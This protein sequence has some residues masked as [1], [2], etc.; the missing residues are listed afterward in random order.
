MKKKD[1]V[2]LLAEDEES[3]QYVFASQ[4]KALGYRSP[5]FVS[6]GID[7]V[8]LALQKRIDIIFMDIRMPGLDGI[9]ATLRIREQEKDSTI[10]IIGLSAFA[11]KAACL[12]AGMNDY[13]QKPVM[14]YQV[15][16]MINKHLNITDKP[17]PTKLLSEPAKIEVAQD[18]YSLEDEKLK[19]IREKMDNLRKHTDIF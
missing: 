12:S 10:P 14:L 18:K 17:Q 1:A 2:I 13:M 8:K 9:S 4:I 19:N 11:Q 15:E 16:E 5:E 6:N 7:A 3:L